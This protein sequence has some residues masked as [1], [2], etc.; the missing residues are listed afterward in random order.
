[1]KTASGEVIDVERTQGFALIA[2]IAAFLG[3]SERTIRRYVRRGG[4]ATFL[5]NGCTEVWVPGV[6]KAARKTRLGSQ[7]GTA[8]LRF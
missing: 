5:V 6:L 8:P 3:M 1:M 2:L 7:V 4:V